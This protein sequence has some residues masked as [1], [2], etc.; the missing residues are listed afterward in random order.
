[1]QA[2]RRR[3][4]NRATK[5]DPDWTSG[6]KGPRIGTDAGDGE[7]GS[8]RRAAT[9][10]RRSQGTGS[11]LVRKDGRGR[12]TWYGKWRVG[13][14]QVMRSLGPRREPGDNVGL[15]RRQA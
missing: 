7:E 13:D 10:V 9:Q 15:T 14:R 5:T 1:M 8:V 12:E 4:T 3:S 6:S 11:L 2:K